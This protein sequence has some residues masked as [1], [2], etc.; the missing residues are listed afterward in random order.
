MKQTLTTCLALILLATGCGK[1]VDPPPADAD[2]IETLRTFLDAVIADDEKTGQHIAGPCWHKVKKWFNL[3]DDRIIKYEIP[4][5]VTPRP[6]Q[7]L[8]V[9]STPV[10]FNYW[11]KSGKYHD[12][13]VGFLERD[14]VDDSWR[15]CG[16][17]YSFAP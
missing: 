5:D 11:S 10:S 15:V 13:M 1:H 17:E 3:N 4:D 9:L 16:L 8:W 6:P 2:S 14:S 7:N 12:W